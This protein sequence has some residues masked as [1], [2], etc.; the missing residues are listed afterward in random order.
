MNLY[1]R[2]SV[3]APPPKRGASIFEE[4]RPYRDLGLARFVLRR[5]GLSI[6][7]FGS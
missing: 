1:G 4:G 7:R 2:P 3:G 5:F 6:E